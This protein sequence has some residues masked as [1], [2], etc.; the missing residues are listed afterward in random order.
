MMLSS[1]TTMATAFIDSPYEAMGENIFD[2]DE[3]IMPVE[4]VSERDVSDEEY[5]H[6]EYYI[7]VMPLNTFTA[8]DLAQLQSAFSSMSTPGPY[9][10]TVTGDID[11]QS[12]LPPVPTGRVVTLTGGGVLSRT[13]QG[14]HFIVAGTLRLQNIVLTGMFNDSTVHGGVSVMSTGRLYMYGGSTITGN[15]NGG[16]SIS[17]G[18]VFIM[19]GGEI[20][21]NTTT[22]AVFAAEGGG[23]N[24]I[25][26]F[27]MHGGTISDN[28]SIYTRYGGGVNN[29]GTFTMY[30]GIISNNEASFGGGV[31]NMGTFYMHDGEITENT[32]RGI[33]G[34]VN[35]M[36][37]LTS[38]G[39]FTMHDGTIVGNEA[40]SGGG[41]QAG[42]NDGVTITTINRG[43]ISENIATGT[44]AVGVMSG[45]GGLNWA[46]EGALN[47]LS[48]APA[49]IFAGNT[50]TALRINHQMNFDN[51]IND[52]GRVNPGNWTGSPGVTHAFNNN[53]IRT[54]PPIYR[55]VTFDLHEGI[56]DF[57]TQT[58]QSSITIT[59]P[60]TIPTLENHIFIGWYTAATG[61]ARFNFNTAITTDTVIHA[62]WEEIVHRIVTF[63]LHEGVGD[64]PAQT[65]ENNTAITAPA[66]DPIRAGHIFIGWYTAATDGTPFNFNTA[67]TADTVIHAR[68][69]LIPPPAHE[70]RNIRVYYY[71]EGYGNL[72]ND[73][74]N[75]AIGRD[76]VHRVG[77]VFS[78]ADVLDMNT[79]DSDNEYVFE[80]WRVFVG[81]IYNPTYI[82]INQLHGSFIVPQAADDEASLISIVAVWSIYEADDETTTPPPSETTPPPSAGNQQGLPRTGIE[83]SVILWSILLGVA[84]LAAIGAVIWIMKSKKKDSSAK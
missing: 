53:D 25:G 44:A 81:G 80:G 64:F 26:T 76:Y 13:A 41:I 62:R 54:T 24:N 70:Y 46:T 18:G 83:S 2:V 22:S 30:N 52:N 78:L 57:P 74:A 58:V 47:N 49:V 65:V 4:E 17:H 1:L 35:N 23:V 15:N 20:V 77:T 55:T 66:T 21:G 60:T 33:G 19:R 68:W 59:E 38:V 84:L 5:D 79:L 73:T 56:G 48:I 10:V 9:L 29:R 11:M 39:T 75:N 72:V 16:V 69:E 67:I 51:N 12:W 63:N 6:E 7:E 36:G 34:G 45:G 32:A 82:T 43:T 61:G 8:S 50:A 71:L 28:I 40:V 14:R 31:N 42:Y 37:T 27:T 3:T